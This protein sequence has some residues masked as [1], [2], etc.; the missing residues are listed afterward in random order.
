MSEEKFR[1]YTRGSESS[2]GNMTIEAESRSEAER[3]ALQDS[4][5]N[6]VA[7]IEKFEMGELSHPDLYGN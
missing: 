4:W 2:T 7:G 1:V 6:Q 5:V 3:I